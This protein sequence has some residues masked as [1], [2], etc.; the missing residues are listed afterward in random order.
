MPVIIP[1]GLTAA[2]TLRAEGIEVIERAGKE[3]E[4]AKGSVQIGIVNLMPTKEATETQLL[5]ALAGTGRMIEA[6]LIAPETHESKN[7]A[8]EHIA[9]FYNAFGEA[10]RRRMD[11]LIVTGAPVEM[12]EF[13]DV[14]YWEELCGIMDHARREIRSTLYICWAAQAALYRFFGIGK[15]PLAAKCFGVFEHRFT[16]AEHALLRGMDEPFLAPHSRHTEVAAGEIERAEGV[17]L[18][19]LSDEAGAY[20]AA[21]DDGRSVFVTGHSEYDADTLKKEYDRDV[22]RGLPIG[23][24]VRYYPEDDPKRQP[25]AVW[26]EHSRQIY[27][28]WIENIV[29]AK[30]EPAGR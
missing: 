22:G 19:A 12:L 7:T 23:I 18:L 29:C 30:S 25:E 1:R 21:E 5:R 15:R 20:L 17:R 8:Q 11:G 10:K 9:R 3:P 14:D 24:P 16:G 2:E 28:S 13:E 26:R 27:G 6:A 4:G